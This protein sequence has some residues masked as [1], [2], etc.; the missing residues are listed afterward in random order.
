Y[1]DS[2]IGRKRA[3]AVPEHLE[4]ASL[5]RELVEKDQIENDPANRKQTV[6][7]AVESRRGGSFGWHPINEERHRQR[8][9]EAEQSREMN[10]DS[11]NGDR[12]EEHHDRERRHDG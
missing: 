8:D 11:Q 7:R 2:W 5:N 6:S 3:Q 9:R 4:Q 12:S 1:L 10:S